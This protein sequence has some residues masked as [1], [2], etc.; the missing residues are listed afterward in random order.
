MNE[1]MS[2]MERKRKDIFSLKLSIDE[3]V[4]KGR[5]YRSCGH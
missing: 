2:I 1:V 5:S 4:A 3:W